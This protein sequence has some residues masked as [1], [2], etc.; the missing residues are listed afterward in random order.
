MRSIANQLRYGLVSLT[1]FSVLLV[2][3][4]LTYL[5]WQQQAQQTK[6]LQQTAVEK[7]G[8]EISD[9]LDKLQRQLNYLS[10]LNGLA[11]FDEDTQRSILEG[12]V[13]SNSAYE[14]AGIL[15]EKNQIVRAMSPY[16]PVSLSSLEITQILADSRLFPQTFGKGQNYI[17]RVEI[18]P[19]TN[20]TTVT[21]AVPIRNR[22][23]EIAGVLFGKI[24]LNFLNHTLSKTIVGNTGYTYI[25]DNRAVLL[26]QKDSNI[27][28]FKPLSLKNKPFV[29][30]LFQT[31]L[32]SSNQT[33]LIYQGLNGEQVLG[34]AT[35]VRRMQWLVVVELPTK[36]AYAPV[37]KMILVM[38][39][40]TGISTFLAVI[41][42]LKFAKSIILPLKILTKA[43]SEM[44]SGQ[45][46]TRVEIGRKNE[47]GTL[48]N[49]FN[50]M[51]K[52][53]QESFNELLQ[54]EQKLR[55]FLEALPIGIFI[56]DKT[57]NPYYANSRSTELLG[58]GIV[59]D[60]NSEQ[61][62]EIYQAYNIETGEIYPQEREPLFCALNG[63]Y[64]RIEDMEIRQKNKNIPLEV[65][66]T[67]IRD[68]KGE[69]LY[70]IAAFTDIT[71]RKK[72]EQLLAEYNR[73]L[74]QQVAERTQELS[75]ALENL[76]TTQQELIQSE[77][78]AALGQLV[79]GVAHEV[80]TPL[81]A[82]RSSAQNI[83]HFL[84]NNTLK[85]PEFFQDITSENLY[86]FSAMLEQS[87]LISPPLS[88][89]E[90][91][92]LR[93]SLISNLEEHNIPNSDIIADTLVDL[94]CYD[95]L[96]T[97]LPFLQKPESH[98]LLEKIYEISTLQKS[99]D[100]ILLATDKAA[101]I[102]FALKTY[103]RSYSSDQKILSNIT[104]G[105]ETALTLYNNL[106]K[107]GIEV[108]RN[109]EPHLPLIWCYPD[110]LNQVWTNLI[111]NAIQA[112]DYQGILE[113]AIQKQTKN[114]AISFTDNG[115]GINPEIMTKI[116]QPF[117]TTKPAGEGTGLGLDIVRKIIEKHSGKIQLE[118]QPGNTTFC[119][120]LPLETLSN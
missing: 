21:L 50:E 27:N 93:K 49:S 25:I 84:Q 100:T 22:K 19:K 109:Y 6:L 60:A 115:P 55:Q 114:L 53:L 103:S 45:L 62:R 94:N 47:L 67:P 65:W 83:D 23:S 11:E 79:A 10:E 39:S 90:K 69:V 76:Q 95:N 97:F 14:L 119:V 12:L 108:K 72:A 30:T 66:A 71:L 28:N 56:I 105:I 4:S 59:K 88:T 8:R 81:G 51:A 36:E 15:N 75:L 70:A 118:S 107:K 17:S 37:I 116:F 74:E 86:Y 89:K 24:N 99:T 32:S 73:T 54:S 87:R 18:D 3:G 7:A 104:E 102:V 13:N 26:A 44:N 85:L 111:H 64:T 33:S 9:Y 42:S 101:K 1:V 35:I 68:E 46:N 40:A 96:D 61:L 112:M 82:I 29:K 57:G 92:L 38:V 120:F 5:S 106:L 58:Q 20:L 16:E 41:V 34:S 110:E 63:Q 2:G 48:G 98:E 31:A 52:R 77:K 78:M 43:A 80:N 117:F 113:I 91:R